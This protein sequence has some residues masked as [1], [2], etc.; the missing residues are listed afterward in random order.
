VQQNGQTH[1]AVYVVDL[2][3]PAAPRFDGPVLKL[4]DAF[5]AEYTFVTNRGSTFFVETTRDAPRGRVVAI[6]LAAPAAA[7][8]RT[9]VPQ[10]DDS[11]DEV[12]AAGGQLVV[13]TMHDVQS[14]LM[15]WSLDGKSLGAIPL[16]GI[17]SVSGLSGKEGDPDLY[18]GLRRTAT[19]RI[20]CSTPRAMARGFRCLSPIGRA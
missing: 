14:R 16:P 1:N 18:Y 8:W 17:G 3:D 6:Q 4:L 9:I 11:I 7:A 12:A 15:A 5:D 2:L 19:K 13:L 20:R 10:S